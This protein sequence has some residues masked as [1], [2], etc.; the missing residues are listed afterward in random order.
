M[1]GKI[2]VCFITVFFLVLSVGCNSNTGGGSSTDTGATTGAEATDERSLSDFNQA[3]VDAGYTLEEQDQPAFDLIGAI[4]GT[5]FYVD[6][7][8]VKIYEYSS[9]KDLE[10]ARKEFDI[11]ADWPSNGRFLLETS[12]EKASEI[13]N[14]LS[15]SSSTAS[16]NQTEEKAAKDEVSVV[17]IGDTIK[18]DRAEITINK[19]E[20]SYDVL[21]D[22]TSSFYTHYAAE[23]GKVYIHIDTDV[24]NIQKQDLG[25]DELMSVKVDYNNGYEY[26]GFPVPE[27]STTGF[28]YANI[29][30][31]APLCT[32]GVRFLVDCPQEVEES[33][34]PVKI[35]FTLSN[36]EYEYVIR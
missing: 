35:I 3:Y 12:N 28:T 4:D 15:V 9:E 26:D 20:F 21:P 31:I 16:Q 33:Q 1:K 7:K 29:V 18:D 8:V 23:S 19:I 24:K 27:D 2:A 11:I 10:D 25:C 17:S 36:K 13:F 30:G 14:S 22:N 6:N 34:N 32:Q 5:M